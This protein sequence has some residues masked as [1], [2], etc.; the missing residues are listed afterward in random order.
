MIGAVYDTWMGLYSHSL[1]ACSNEVCDTKELMW[2]DGTPY[3][4]D[5]AVSD[6]TYSDRNV[7]GNNYQL[8][9]VPRFYNIYAWDARKFMCQVDCQPGKN[10]V[11]TSDKV[12]PRNVAFLSI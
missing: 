9:T 8:L 1:G 4:H 6:H 7:V 10:N 12:K 11:L 2:V 5:L 3:Q